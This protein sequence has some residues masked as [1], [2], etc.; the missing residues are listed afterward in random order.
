MTNLEERITEL[1]NIRRNLIGTEQ[2]LQDNMKNEKQEADKEI[3]DKY[4]PLIK[5]TAK[6]ILK[7]EEDMDKFYEK[8]VNYSTFEYRSFIE[9][10]KEIIKVYEGENF[11]YKEI[12]YFPQPIRKS[13][14][15]KRSKV[16]FL[17]KRKTLINQDIDISKLYA[18]QKHGDGIVLEWD[19][20]FMGLDY[21]SFYKINDNGE[22][23]TNIKLNRFPYLK[24][25]I[26]FIISYHLE[27]ENYVGPKLKVEEIEKLKN[28]FIFDNLD[29]I[30]KY[31]EMVKFNEQRKMEKE[32]EKNAEYRNKQLLKSLSKRERM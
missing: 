17:D 9:I 2:S 12:R 10:M 7:S 14:Y 15:H 29:N 11:I 31:H 4:L 27:N 16:L 3:A 28:Q 6:R 1:R 20:T 24:Q 30:K 22:L 13:T 25:F 8:L 23:K 21:I 26:D 19:D 5:N 18:V 32:I